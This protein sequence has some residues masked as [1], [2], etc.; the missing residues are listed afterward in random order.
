MGVIWTWKQ[1]W[2]SP[3][4]FFLALLAA[5]RRGVLGLRHCLI[6]WTVSLHPEL[7][8]HPHPTHIMPPPPLLRI[9]QSVQCCVT[10]SP[11][12]SEVWHTEEGKY[13]TSINSTWKIL[14]KTHQ[15]T[16]VCIY[17]FTFPSR[18]YGICDTLFPCSPEPTPV[19][20]P[21]LRYNYNIHHFQ[22]TTM[23]KISLIL[24]SMVLNVC[25]TLLT[26]QAPLR[27]LELWSLDPEVE[28]EELTGGVVVV[29]VKWGRA[30][31]GCW[32][33][34]MVMVFWQFL[35]LL[36]RDMRLLCRLPGG[37]GASRVHGWGVRGPW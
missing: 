15:P 29:N 11:P 36:A 34:S 35:S 14:W 7:P 23:T 8:P 37:R 22:S 20:A 1:S 18:L 30:S 24:L 2:I 9:F 26:P 28:S 19:Q 31:A 13:S 16:H 4:F 10:R 12:P 33:F 6:L 3:A 27:N 17:V 5:L 25:W 21:S 32:K